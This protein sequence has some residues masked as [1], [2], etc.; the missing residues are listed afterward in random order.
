MPAGSITARNGMAP[1][2]VSTILPNFL[3]LGPEITNREEVDALVKLGV[4]R[5]LNVAIECD[6]QG[7]LRLKER[8]E[9]YMKLPMRDMVE[10]SGVAKGMRDACNFLGELSA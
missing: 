10:E 7:E 1:F 8:F 9:R 4:K 6:D 3:Y 2:I 5:I